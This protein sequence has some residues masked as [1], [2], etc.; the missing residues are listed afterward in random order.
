MALVSDAAAATTSSTGHPVPASD[1]ATNPKQTLVLHIVLAR[2]SGPEGEEV[3][4]ARCD[5]LQNET[6]P[7][8]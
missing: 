1:H 4:E 7:F 2:S 8:C 3:T 6:T 5:V